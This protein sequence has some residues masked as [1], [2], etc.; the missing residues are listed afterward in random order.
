LGFGE[1]GFGEIGHNRY[2]VISHYSNGSC[3]GEVF[4]G[5][6]VQSWETTSAV[7]LSRLVRFKSGR[8]TFLYPSG[9]AKVLLS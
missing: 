4:S 8:I 3:V 5:V 7:D 2:K 1:T 6:Y 9:I